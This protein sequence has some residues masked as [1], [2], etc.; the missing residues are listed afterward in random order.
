VLKSKF[1]KREIDD[2]ANLAFI[3]GKTNREISN[4]EPIKYLPKMIKEYGKD[5]F[6]K[7]LIPLDE[8]LYKI[9][10]YPKFLEVRRGLI[11]KRLNEILLNGN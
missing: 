7:H 9:E 2:L 6:V 1:K 3:G 11:T 10:N 4:K 8:E 5:V